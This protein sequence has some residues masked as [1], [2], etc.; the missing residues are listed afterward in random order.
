[1]K[2]NPILIFMTTFISFHVVNIKLT[3]AYLSRPT[4]DHGDNCCHFTG[5][6]IFHFSVLM[7]N[8]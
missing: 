5:K 2:E 1:M 4:S 3:H 8:E 6:H 7:E